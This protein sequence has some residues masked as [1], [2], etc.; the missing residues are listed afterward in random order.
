MDSLRR[1]QSLLAVTLVSFSLPGCLDHREAEPTRASDDLVLYSA[2][3][4]NAQLELDDTPPG[5]PRAACQVLLVHNA[6]RVSHLTFEVQWTPKDDSMR[7]LRAW[8]VLP[9]GSVGNQ[10][11]GASPLAVT[12]RSF[13]ATRG[14][15]FRMI[16]NRTSLPSP[17]LAIASPQPIAVH[18]GF[19]WTVAREDTPENGRGLWSRQTHCDR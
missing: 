4:R 16:V 1:V 15:E 2:V 3:N 5:G 13:N 7:V 6:T 17:S 11:E 12:S 9:D 10:V 8:I 19:V 14:E 18:I